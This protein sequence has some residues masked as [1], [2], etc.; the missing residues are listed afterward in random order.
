VYASGRRHQRL[1]NT[2]FRWVIGPYR[3]RSRGMGLLRMVSLPFPITPPLGGLR[4]ARSRSGPAPLPRGS[5]RRRPS[6]RSGRSSSGAWMTAPPASATASGATAVRAVVRRSAVPPR[7][8]GA[9]RW[10]VKQHASGLTPRQ[11]DSVGNTFP[12][13][14]KALRSH[15]LAF[16]TAEDGSDAT[17][18]P[19]RCQGRSSW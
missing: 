18:T 19:A 2:R 7:I 14:R 10:S 11:R 4:L 17:P 6:R 3:S 12:C 15:V 1:R 8:G 13:L 5:A 16:S 9:P